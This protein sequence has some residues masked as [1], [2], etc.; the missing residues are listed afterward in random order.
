MRTYA[1]SWLIW[2]PMVI[3]LERSRG[4]SH[5][6]DHGIFGT[7]PWWATLAALVGGYG[8][9]VAALLIAGS[10]SLRPSSLVSAARNAWIV[11][12]SDWS[13]RKCSQSVRMVHACGALPN[14]F[15]TAAD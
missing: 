2:L 1:L 6:G 11:R 14:L 12:M 4:A 10:G 3:V 8:P 7:I 5:S 13:R 15:R 9:S